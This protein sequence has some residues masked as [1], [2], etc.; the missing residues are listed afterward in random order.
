MATYR[1]PISPSTV[2]RAG[3]YRHLLMQQPTG[4][5]FAY[6]VRAQLGNRAVGIYPS[7]SSARS[8]GPSTRNRKAGG[9]RVFK[10]SVVKQTPRERLVFQQTLQ[11]G[12]QFHR[13]HLEKFLL[14][15]PCETDSVSAGLM[16]GWSERVMGQKGFFD[17]ERRLEA[18]SA[19]GDPLVSQLTSWPDRVPS[20]A[21]DASPNSYTN[22][23]GTEETESGL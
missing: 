3:F 7:V 9:V 18:I 2:I 10:R 16:G 15:S 5:R 1:F 4:E 22:R 23:D 8:H 6:S 17:V 21:G 20:N 11:T 12:G 19:K 13:R 14:P